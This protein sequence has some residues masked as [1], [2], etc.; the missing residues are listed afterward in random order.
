MDLLGEFDSEKKAKLS[1]ELLAKEK[2]L[3]KAEE[4]IKQQEAEELAKIE[5]I[6]I[7]KE[8]EQ[9]KRIKIKKVEKKTEQDSKINEEIS[10][11]KTDSSSDNQEELIKANFEKLK[12]VKT[13]GEKID[14]TKFKK[15]EL[16][17]KERKKE[18][19]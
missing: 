16:V 8:A 7:K 17:D 15:E 9:V 12:G 3:A 4:I 11:K 18:L 2:E 5:Q 14:L 10:A 1:A 19:E 13:T 6:K